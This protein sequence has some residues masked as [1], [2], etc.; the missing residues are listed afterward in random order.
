[1]SQLET[2]A[3]IAKN[4]VG[5]GDRLSFAIFLATALHG[6]LI[7]GIGFNIATKPNIPATFEVTIATFKSAEAP[8]KADFQ[9]QFNQEASGT[10]DE[11]RELTT[12]DPAPF[13]DTQ[14][15]DVNPLPETLAIKASE[16]QPLNQ[17]SSEA[18]SNIKVSQVPKP[19]E[20]DQ[21]TPQEGRDRQAPA[22]TSEIAS[23]RAKR[24]RQKQA[25]ASKPR[26]RRLTSVSTTS[27]TDAEY[28]NH[29][30]QRIKKI[31]NENFPQEALDKRI[32]GQ[33]RLVTV[34]KADGTIVSVDLLQSS[35]HNL[36]DHSALQIVHMA[37][38]F[39]PFP[40]EIAK[41]V[42]QLE[43]IR[44]WLFDITGLSTS[45]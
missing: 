6:L 7:L 40:P 17:L 42:D 27:S 2:Q 13:T 15:R 28:L 45:N 16:S 44:T 30:E 8:D 4:A 41:E 12:R 9:A 43:I 33:L 38:P 32:F 1:M 34:L 25:Y 10:L 29:W 31:G 39:P 21:R 26:I 36:L 14:I 3:I 22:T 23:L 11:V 37:A 5:A 20:I 35:G 19:E 18:S 24:D